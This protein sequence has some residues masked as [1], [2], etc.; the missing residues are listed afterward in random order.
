ME[1][2]EQGLITRQFDDLRSHQVA[3]VIALRM[4]RPVFRRLAQMEQLRISVVLARDALPVIV[5]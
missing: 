4:R 1:R 3:Q 2:V 5:V